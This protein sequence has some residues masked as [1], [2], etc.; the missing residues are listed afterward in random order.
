MASLFY[1]TFFSFCV[2]AE[3]S[4]FVHQQ[5]TLIA[6]RGRGLYEKLLGELFVVEFYKCLGTESGNR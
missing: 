5:S 4:V 2:R 6:I 3:N 1:V